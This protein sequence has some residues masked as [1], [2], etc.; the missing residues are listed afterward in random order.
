MGYN[1]NQVSNIN[2]NNNI[3]VQNQLM[4][5]NSNTSCV[6]NI[7]NI[8]SN[9]DS[10]HNSGIYDY[11]K[12]IE[13]EKINFLQRNV[14]SFRDNNQISCEIFYDNNDSNSY[15]PQN[16]HSGKLI[17][18]QGNSDTYHFGNPDS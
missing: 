13:A 14:N 8:S 3:L 9:S 10:N 4:I 16:Y 15:Q 7:G 17:V 18:S 5:P 11:G 12:N 1:Q 6:S 2:Q